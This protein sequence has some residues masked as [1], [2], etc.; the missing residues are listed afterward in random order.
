MDDIRIF[1]MPT[2]RK[3]PKTSIRSTHC[4]HWKPLESSSKDNHPK[5][6]ATISPNRTWTFGFFKNLCDKYTLNVYLMTLEE[7]DCYWH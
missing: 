2:L 3:W 4:E 7:A 5:M 1:T 6:H